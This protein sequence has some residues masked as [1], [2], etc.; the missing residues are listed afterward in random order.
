[1]TDQKIQTGL[2]L[3]RAFYEGR[4]DDFVNIIIECIDRR[5]IAIS[6]ASAQRL[7]DAARTSASQPSEVS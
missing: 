3:N 1:M 6:E 5:L 2:E 4:G 7:L